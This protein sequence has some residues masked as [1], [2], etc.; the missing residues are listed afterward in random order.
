M[1]PNEEP[2]KYKGTL[3]WDGD[4]GMKPIAE[5]EKEEL[6]EVVEALYKQVPSKIRIPKWISAAIEAE[7][8]LGGDVSM[9]HAIWVA[10]TAYK[11]GLKKGEKEYDTE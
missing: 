2:E 7:T 4:Y 3:V 11:A 6:I 9:T 1:T 10:E 5:M 8:D